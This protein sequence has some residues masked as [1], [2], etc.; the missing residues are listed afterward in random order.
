MLRLCLAALSVAFIFS[1]SLIAREEPY[2]GHRPPQYGQHPS[3]GQQQHPYSGQQ[4]H[5][6]ANMNSA[7]YQ[8]NNA[9]MNNANFHQVNGV[10]ANTG[11]GAGGAVIVPETTTV[12]PVPD[13][14]FGN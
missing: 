9:N 1:N 7:N 5:P 14:S 10:N 3:G 2:E 6:N 8:H 12:V 13:S 4:Q 11:A